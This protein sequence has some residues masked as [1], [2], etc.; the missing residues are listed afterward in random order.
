MSR[1]PTTLVVVVIAVA[2]L[3]GGWFLF[4]PVESQRYHQVDTVRA[5]RSVIRLSETMTYAKGPIAR[6]EL[7]LDNDNGKSSASYAIEDRK[8]TIAKFNEPIA[9]Y[10]VTFAFDLLVRDGI[11]ELQTPSVFHGNTNTVYT[12]SIAQTAG[13]RS[14]S[15]AFTFADPHWLATASEYA[16]HLDRNK[17]LPSK[18]DLLNLRATANPD[19]RYQKIVNDFSSFGPPRFKKTVAE[20]RRKL[21]GS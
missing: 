14:G 15:H 11:W 7:R 16:L 2:G 17:P 4:W 3:I 5:Q 9:G 13:A 18:D 6:E 20:A 10:D 21:L 1:F 12:I 8:G 19:P